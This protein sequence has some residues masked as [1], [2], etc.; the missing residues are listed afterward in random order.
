MERFPP[1][2]DAALNDAQRAVAAAIASGKRGGVRGPFIALLHNPALTQH[3]QALGEHLRFH[4][5]F[6]PSVLEIAILITARHWNCA[7]EWY[8]HEKIARAAGLAPAVIAALVAGATPDGLDLESALVHDFACQ[9]LQS[10]APSDAIY[11]QAERH[12]GKDGVLDLLALVGYY[13]LL[14]FVLNTARPAVPADGGIPL[15]PRAR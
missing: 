7:Y 1:I 5:R 3:V 10:G 15:P 9:T 13:S 8:A 11:A 12:F 2:P 14:A 6:A 4:T